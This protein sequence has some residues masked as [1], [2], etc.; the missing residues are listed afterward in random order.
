MQNNK[1]RRNC[2]I[3]SQSKRVVSTRLANNIIER[4]NPLFSF[5]INIFDVL[6]DM[7]N[8]EFIIPN[9]THPQ[10]LQDITNETENASVRSEKT[11]LS[12]EEQNAVLQALLKCCEEEKP[13]CGAIKT[14][15]NNFNLGRNT[16][17]HIW[18]RAC[19]RLS[20]GT[21][22]LVNKNLCVIKIYF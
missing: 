3:L 14:I 12:M 4:L 17:G 11:D 7:E 8:E 13:Q 16:V 15:A 9:A 19:P 10:S 2:W 20:V 18:A 21:S 22:N 6:F 5:P 1:Y